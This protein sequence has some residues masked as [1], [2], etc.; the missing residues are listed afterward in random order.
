[1]SKTWAT[2]TNLCIAATLLRIILLLYGEWQDANLTVKYTD[3]DYMVFTD[4]ARHVTRGESPY[5][6]ATYRYTP[7]LA[8]LLTPNIHWFFSFG[9]CI[10]AM[11][12]IIVGYII[13]QILVLRGMPSEK[14][15]WLDSLWLLNPMVA[16]ISTR[17]NAESLLAAMV[18]GTLYLILIRRF[19]PAC[20]LF[21]LAVHFKIYPVIYAVPL[22]FLLDK[23]YGDPV[24]FPRMMWS[25][26][27]TRLYVLQRYLSDGGGARFE[28]NEPPTSSS[29]SSPSSSDEEYTPLR[30]R[31]VNQIRGILREC[32]L[33][34]T[35][36][37]I[38]FGAVS[39]GVFF[40][41]TWFM[42]QIYGD[43]FLQHTYLYHVTRK[44]H[45]HNFSVW[46]YQMYLAFDAPVAGKLMGLL[47]FVPQ[48]ALVAATGIVF[49]KDI[50]F[51]CFIQTFL[52]V[53]FN[54]VCT[55]QYF[56]WYICLLPLILPSTT[57]R[58][59]WKGL[60]LIAAWAAG[61]GIWLNYAYHLEFLG[62]NTFF[63][64][65]IASI[66]FFI[67][68]CWIAVELI[69]NHRFEYVYGNTGRIRWVFGMG[70][71]GFVKSDIANRSGNVRIY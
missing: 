50:F 39:A 41:L 26:Q 66:V 37:R 68:N 58:F 64:I 15:L 9:K 23:R 11:T 18:L 20:A 24:D 25:Y 13:H 67:I 54:K 53:T 22:L 70:E 40:A 33:F 59:R 2:F 19:Y 36:S 30:D 45:R 71:P 43:E 27:Q 51:A 14:A 34:F 10:F 1:M 38:L 42:Y 28:I 29:P 48:L 21:G 7:L 57:I 44:D 16:N 32:M 4:A 65:W 61:Q 6:R 46:F 8:I 12:D 17:G 62:E 35:P 52:F 47:A 60:T 5:E 31:A 56:M 55:S 69:L 63:S 3:I 49:A